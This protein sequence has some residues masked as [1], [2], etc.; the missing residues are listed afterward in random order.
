MNK[1]IYVN[2]YHLS[3][4]QLSETDLKN[5]SSYYTS[6]TKKDGVNILNLYVVVKE[7]ENKK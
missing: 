2:T 5:N 1:I 7:K 4:E 6:I 3:D